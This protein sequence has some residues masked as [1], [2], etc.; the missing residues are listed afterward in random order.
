MLFQLGVTSLD[1]E[2][3]SCNHWPVPDLL[4]IQALIDSV[5]SVVWNGFRSVWTDGAFLSATTDNQM[6]AEQSSSV[7]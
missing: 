3:F 6:S 2:G 1:D 5:H 4:T 7:D